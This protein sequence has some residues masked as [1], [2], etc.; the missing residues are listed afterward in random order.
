MTDD[1]KTAADVVLLVTAPG[2]ETGDAVE[3]KLEE[4]SSPVVRMDVGDFPVRLR[5]ATTNDSSRWR[6]RLWTDD[7]AVEVDQIRSVYYRRP[8][9]F[10]MP[11]GLSNGDSAFAK[12]EARLGFGG[13]FASLRATWVNN[14]IRIA[15][16]EYKPLQLDAAVEAGITTPRTLIT[17][18]YDELQDFASAVDGPVV[19]K[20][21]SSLVLSDEST[22]KAVYTTIIDPATVD[23]R[24]LATTAHL[25]Q[26][27]IPKD[28]EVRV[29][30]IGRQPFAAVIRAGSEAAQVDW[31]ADYPSLT[32]ER[33]EVPPGIVDSMIQY[34]ITFGLSYGAFDFVVQPDGTWRFLECNPNGQW[35]WLE[36]EANLPI[37]TA[38]AEFLTKGVGL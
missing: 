27:W 18:D 5:L 6:G 2:D 15:V 26:E 34:L 1:V 36:H 9:H 13:A 21:F 4:L 37:A 19:C 35:L 32:Y 11:P 16:A 29:T 3:A 30:M 12:T 31:R 14:P 28:F 24:Q 17:N 38:I 10:N 20:A 8:T 25:F 23:A 7:V 33:I 22:P